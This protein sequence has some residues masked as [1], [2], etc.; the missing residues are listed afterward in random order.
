MNKFYKEYRQKGKICKNVDE[1]RQLCYNVPMKTDVI[2]AAL[3][4]L[5]MSEA[6]QT[7]YIS[8]L[9]DGRATARMLADR[10]G[11]TRPSVYDQL[12]KLLTLNIVVELAVEGKAHFAA[13]D[14]KYLESLLSDRIDRLEQS[15]ESLLAALPDITATLDTVVPKIRFFEGEEGMKQLLK[16]IMWH[17]HTTVVALWND[18]EMSKMYD[19]AFLVWWHERRK[20]RR[21]RIEWLVGQ[22]SLDKNPR[23]YIDDFDTITYTTASKVPAMTR[24]TYAHKVV[25]ISSQKEAFG[26]I[27]ESQEFA[28]LQSTLVTAEDTYTKLSKKQT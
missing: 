28:T 19:S 2:S 12:K 18:T 24:L 6:E 27:V 9:R 4:R 10:T 11:L 25:C 1:F 3:R 22:N 14:I 16:D 13:A 5:E 8:L 17:E 7:I 20:I 26:F 21:I 15:R 23:Y